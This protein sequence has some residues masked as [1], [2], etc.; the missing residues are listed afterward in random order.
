MAGRTFGTI[1]IHHDLVLHHVSRAAI[2]H[3]ITL[4]LRD[5]SCHQDEVP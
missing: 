5:K 3:D 2:G 1:E 4:F